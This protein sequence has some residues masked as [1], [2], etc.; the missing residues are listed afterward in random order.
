VSELFHTPWSIDVRT[1]DGG[2]QLILRGELDAAT[3]VELGQHVAA[4]P[5]G[6]VQL[7]LGGVTFMDSSG[8][9]AILESHRRL[10][11]HDRRLVLTHTSTAVQRVL[12]LSGV[13]AHLD[14]SA[15]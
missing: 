14:L 4:S 11:A 8:L 1:V 15:G 7:D 12:E 9:A 2:T 5:A 10:A 6:D 13:A 3:A